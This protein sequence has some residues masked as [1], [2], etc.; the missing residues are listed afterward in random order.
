M[1]FSIKLLRVRRRLSLFEMGCGCD[2]WKVNFESL[3]LDAGHGAMEI[4][5]ELV[6]LAQ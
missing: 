3:V 6:K 2:T 5:R 1:S 4:G